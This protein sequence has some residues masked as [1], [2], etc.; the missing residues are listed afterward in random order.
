[1]KCWRSSMVALTVLAVGLA[2]P[3]VRAHD[4]HHENSRLS[5]TVAFG[6]GLNTTGAANH[7]VVPM[8]IRIQTGGVVNFAVAGLHQI[9]VYLPGKAPEDVV[10]PDTGLFIDDPD[11]LYYGGINPTGT[12]P[13]GISNAQNRVESVSFSDPGTYLVICNIR[14]HFING[15]YAFVTVEDPE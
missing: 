10:V 5:V 6:A 1:M 3:S 9:S 13:A 11:Q 15:M 14:T 12:P 4:D 8:N 2:A 7:H